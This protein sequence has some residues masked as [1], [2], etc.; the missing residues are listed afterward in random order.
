MPRIA[1]VVS[2][3]GIILALDKWL[4]ARRRNVRCISEKYHK[5]STVSSSSCEDFLFSCFSEDRTAGREGEG[6]KKDD[7]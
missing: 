3:V 5:N 1:D 4:R 6:E 7:E 2:K